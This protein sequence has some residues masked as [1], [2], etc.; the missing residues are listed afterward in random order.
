MM[1]CS[2]VNKKNNFNVRIN[3]LQFCLFTEQ[4]HTFYFNVKTRKKDSKKRQLTTSKPLIINYF[5]KF[6]IHFLRRIS[7]AF[8]RTNPV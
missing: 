4:T 8:F 1:Y 3:E 6:T 7:E 5:K 2:L